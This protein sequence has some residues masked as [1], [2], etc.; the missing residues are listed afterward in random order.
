MEEELLHLH[1]LII[2]LLKFELL[3]L[4][5]YLKVL[6]PLKFTRSTTQNRTLVLLELDS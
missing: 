1:L 2:K 5:H 3:L 6:L 4:L